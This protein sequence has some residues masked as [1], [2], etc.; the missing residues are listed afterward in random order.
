M[1]DNIDIASH[2]TRAVRRGE[3]D[4]Q[5]TQTIVAERTYEMTSVEDLW[6]AITSAERIRRWLLP[7]GG[8]LRL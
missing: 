6:D 1:V 8:D 3:R 5:P 7:I 2:V 4:G